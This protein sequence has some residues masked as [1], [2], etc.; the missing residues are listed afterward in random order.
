M[1]KLLFML[2]LPVL[3]GTTLQAQNDKAKDKDKDKTKEKIVNQRD[4]DLDE[5]WDDDW[6]EDEG[7]TVEFKA[8]FASSK[9]R[10]VIFEMDKSKV[11]IEGYDGEELLITAVGVKEAP[12]RA[13]G[14]KPLYNTAVDNSGIGL[15]VN[16][17]NNVMRV[18]KASRH[19]ARYTVKVPRKTAIMYEEVNW[20]GGNLSVANIEG[21]VEVKLNNSSMKL[22]N[23]TGPVTA[24]TT[25]GNIIVTFTDLNQQKPSSIRAINGHIDV[26]LPV[27]AKSNLKMSTHNGEVYTDFEVDI[28]NKGDLKKVGG[29]TIEG[30]T[31][32]GGVQL[33]LSTINSDIYL[34]KKK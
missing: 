23:I 15:S 8:K 31:N 27:G 4:N 3:A 32:G 33:T 14:L 17:E 18:V 28:K 6:E 11:T 10:K 9:D 24:N 2:I 13:E 20:N 21:D 22:T 29:S 1:K 19:D 34:R 26:A 16:Q 12:K 5:D 7:K 30:A 25:N